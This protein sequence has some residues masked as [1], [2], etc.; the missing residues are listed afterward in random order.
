MGDDLLQLEKDRRLKP[1]L[2]GPGLPTRNHAEF[3]G[4]KNLTRLGYTPK[5]MRIHNVTAITVG[6]VV[7]LALSTAAQK[8]VQVELR[9]GQGKMVGTAEMAPAPQGVNIRLNLANL[10]PGEHGIHIHSV[11]KCE[12]PAFTTAGGHLNPDMKHHG[13]QNPEGPHAGDI[14]NITIDA[15]GMMKGTIVAPGVTMGD[16]PHS[17]FSNGGTALVIHAKA[18]DMKSDPAGNAGVRIACGVIVKPT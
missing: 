14:P 11:A 6:L 10:T 12:G 3:F 17:I 1:A 8:P 7:S 15:H 4:G 5:T 13:L 18:D 9:D 16:D 2:P